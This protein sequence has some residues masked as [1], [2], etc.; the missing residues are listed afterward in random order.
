MKCPHCY[1]QETKVIDSRSAND[2][3][4]IRRRRECS[5][6]R[7][8]FSTYEEVELLNFYVIKKDGRRELY[9]RSKLV[10][11]V[12]R[13]CEKRPIPEEKILKMISRLEQKIREGRKREI[14]SRVIGDLVMKEL[15]KIDEIAYIRF[16][17][18]Y[19]SFK[20]AESLAEELKSFTNLRQKIC[21]SK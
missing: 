14:A 13:A 18:V 11:G 15:K 17:S 3:L 9:D 2:G 4:A 16:A 21:K 12:R 1:A 7:A 8:R 20:D 6:C 10:R 19:K 5:R